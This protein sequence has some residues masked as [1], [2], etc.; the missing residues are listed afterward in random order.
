VSI[1]VGVGVAVLVDGPISQP[2]GVAA[3]WIMYFGLVTSPRR[4]SSR[5]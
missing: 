5:R 4:S 3:E 1:F 2:I